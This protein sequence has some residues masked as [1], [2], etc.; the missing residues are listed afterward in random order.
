MALICMAC[1]DTIENGRTGFTKKTLE[2]LLNTVDFTKH[3]LAVIDNNSC[4]E[5]LEILKKFESDFPVK[6]RLAI[7]Y[8][9]KNIGTAKAINKGIRLRKPGQHVIKMDNDVAIEMAGWVDEMEECIAREPKIG[10]VGLKRMDLLESPDHP[11]S[12]YRSQ[13]IML[14]HQ[15]GD[16]WIVCEKINH[17]MGTCQMISSALLDKIGGFEQ[18]SLYGYDDTILCH[19]SSLLSFI[20]VYLPHIVVHHLDMGG[21]PEHAW[22]I[23]Q[24]NKFEKEVETM[25]VD[26][27]KKR[28]PMYV[29]I[30]S[31]A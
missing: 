14:P 30:F 7:I 12:Y 10:L 20:N 3:Q 19:K 25:L 2:S 17:M 16:R 23:Q 13:L 15:P 29:D 21:T 22:K 9:H 8:N 28:R 1:F 26:F 24:A 6:E 5:T 27:K 31:E 4:D 18:P 11:N